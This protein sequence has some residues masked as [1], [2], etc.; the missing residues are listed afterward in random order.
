MTW[1]SSVAAGALLIGAAGAVL[2][3]STQSPHLSMAQAHPQQVPVSAAALSCPQPPAAPGSTTRLFAVGPGPVEASSPAPS[4]R[5]STGRSATDELATTSLPRVPL[6][7]ALPRAPGARAGALVTAGGALAVGVTA[8]ELST[9][10][11]RRSSGSAVTGCFA[12]RPQWW[13]TGVDTSI[14]TTTH[15]QVSNPGTGVAV[16]DLALLGPE[17]PVRAAGSRDLAV[18]P[19]STATVDLAGLA[20]GRAALTVHVAATRG[21]VSAAV[22]T[23]RLE[24]LTPTGTEWVPPSSEPSRAVVVDAGVQGATTQRLVI[25]N[26]GPRQQLVAVRIIDR[27]GAFVSTALPDVQVPPESVVVKAVTSITR[28]STAAVELTSAAPITG[29]IVS[30]VATGGTRDFA[31]SGVSDPLSDPAVVPM[32]GGARLSV[33][34]TAT[35][36]GARS[37]RLRSVDGAGRQVASQT[38]TVP[39]ART[40]SWSAPVGS[41]GSYVVITSSERDGLQAVATYRAPGGASQLPVLAGRRTVLEPVVVP[42]HP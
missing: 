13:F 34:L 19:R 32:W 33:S 29:A 20:P 21:T 5:L 9:Y 25:A 42:L 27:S 12:P 22:S 3:A 6:R 16:V 7:V 28:R 31:V 18:A 10:S 1:R 38:V 39:G 26:P 23:T 30:E 4:L 40:I 14:G 35:S 8:A 15:L 37:V 36:P 24:G 2:A 11:S 41:R 17:G